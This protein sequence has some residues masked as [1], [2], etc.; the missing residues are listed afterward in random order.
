MWWKI[1]F[2]VLLI[3]TIIGFIVSVPLLTSLTFADWR[4]VAESVLIV[5]G[6]YAYVFKK[7]VF[8]SQVWKILFWY[9]IIFWSLDLLYHLFLGQSLDF[10]QVLFKNS[11]EVSGSIGG[12]FGVLASIILG[13]P[14]LY[15]IYKLAYRK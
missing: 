11:S 9:L 10:L 3:L 7:E 14:A 4:G 6:A 5:I 2:W 12:D 13:L 8:R 1:Y 15:A